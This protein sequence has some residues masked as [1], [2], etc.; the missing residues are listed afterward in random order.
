MVKRVYG[1]WTQN[2]IEIDEVE[3]DGDRHAFEMSVNGRTVVTI[4]AD[5]PENTYVIR[6][7][8]DA[9]E[10]VRDWEDEDG[11]NVGMLITQRTTGLR[12]TLRGI[13]DE[14]GCYNGELIHG[15][16]GTYWIDKVNAICYEYVT[17]DLGLL[18]DDLTDE[19]LLRVRIGGL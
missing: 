12:E 6:E 1:T 11:N 18:V 10:D 9:N 17:D 3:L 14:G 4:Y 5:S 7:A 19:D 16:Y 15:A 8:L 2:G 13:E